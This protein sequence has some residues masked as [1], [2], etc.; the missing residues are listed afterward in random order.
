M[1]REEKIY[2]VFIYLIQ[3]NKLFKYNEITTLNIYDELGNDML[4]LAT[5]YSNNQ[6]IDILFDKCDINHKN[7][8]F[9]Y[10]RIQICLFQIMLF[11]LEIK[12]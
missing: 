11:K 8:L 6:L 2:E 12:I 3:L 7:V 1:V 4:I 5:I 9:L 10:N